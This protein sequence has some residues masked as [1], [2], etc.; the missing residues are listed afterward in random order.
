MAKKVFGG[1]AAA[2]FGLVLSM[3]A[4][5]ADTLGEALSDAYVNSDLLE[6]NRYLLRIQDEGVAQQVAALR[7]VVNFIASRR[8]DRPSD[9]QTSTIG[10]TADLLIYDN[11]GSR[12]A[13]AAA[14]ESVLAARQQLIGLEASVLLDAVSAYMDV[15]RDA[16]VVGVR[17][18]NVRVVTQQLRAARDRFEVGE[19]TR[20]DVALAESQLATARSNLAAARGQLA[21][22]RELFEISVGR[23]PEALSG[24]GDT[25][26]LPAS[27]ADAEALARQHHPS[28]IALQ[29][30]VSANQHNLDAARSDYGPTINLQAQSNDTLRGRTTG[31]ADSL[32]LSLTQPL[33]RGGRLFALERVALATLSASQAEL[34][35][36]TRVNVQSV[37]NAYARLRIASAQI[38]ATDQGIR[39][40]QIAFDGV[41]EEA[42]LGARTTLDVLDAEQDLLDARIAR[43]Q[44]QADLYTA[45]YAVLA[46]A[47][48]LTVE[49]LD[50]DVP[51]YDPQAYSDAFQN[52]PARLPSAQGDRLD[53]LLQRLGRD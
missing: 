47:G 49:H 43:I 12:L 26:A 29:H 1:A 22:S 8:W 13:V 21:I 5:H 37:G 35:Y 27:E 31:R 45:S 53:S 24:P 42:S 11:G 52:A 10:L 33:Y 41:R 15:W 18:S 40:A 34:N 19:D 16:Q 7:P 44:A 51:R 14:R 30:Q 17:E 50:L 4:T 3:G 38:Q 25:P 23:P 6:Q 20:T 9:V 32:T 28:I 39:A 2:V 48:L 46:A 36:Q